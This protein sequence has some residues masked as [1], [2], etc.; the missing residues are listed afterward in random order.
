VGRFSRDLPIETAADKMEA[1]RRGSLIQT[2][3]LELA[4]GQYTLDA[5][6]MDRQNQKISARRTPVVVAAARP[7][8]NVS[9]LS[10]I[11]RIDPAAGGADTQD[12]FRFEGGEVIPTLDNSIQ[13][14]VTG[15]LSYYLVVYPLPSMADKPELTM[16]F[17]KDGAPAGDANPELPPA[18]DGAIPY[19][20]TLPLANFGP[21]KY[22]LHTTVKHGATVAEETASFVINP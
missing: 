17:T 2:A 15:E 20:A 5:A 7:G 4:A 22:E 11:R 18:K 19:V 14:S 13:A 1:L 9:N 6:V 3:H 21:G 10:L 12:P 8:V 16:Q